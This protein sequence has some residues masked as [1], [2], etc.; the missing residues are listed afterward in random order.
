MIRDLFHI[1]L[2]TLPTGALMAVPFLAVWLAMEI[3]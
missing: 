2:T 3:C 1:Y